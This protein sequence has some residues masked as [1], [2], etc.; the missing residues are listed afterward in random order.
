MFIQGN[1]TRETVSVVINSSIDDFLIRSIQVGQQ[2]VGD[3]RNDAFGPRDFRRLAALVS[4]PAVSVRSST[5]RTLRPSMSPI[6]AVASVSV[7]LLRRFAT[8][9]SSASDAGHRRTPS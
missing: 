1:R 3:A 4:V 8:M 7:G 6:T 5:K 2:G 9:A